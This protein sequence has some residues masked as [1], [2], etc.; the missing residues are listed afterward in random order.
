MPV[1]TLDPAF[2]EQHAARVKAA[3]RKH[4]HAP[5]WEDKVAAIDRMRKRSAAL[6]QAREE[7]A[8]KAVESA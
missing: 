8:R 5:S 6:E 7:N 3:W 1:D 4:A 2:L